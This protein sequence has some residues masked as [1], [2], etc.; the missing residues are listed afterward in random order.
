VIL[1]VLVPFATMASYLEFVL[2]FYFRN[3]V[4][5]LC[6]VFQTNVPRARDAP[7]EDGFIAPRPVTTACVVGAPRAPRY[8]LGRMHAYGSVFKIPHTK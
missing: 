1:T 2:L 5:A 3:W 6:C 7:P 8:S 4:L